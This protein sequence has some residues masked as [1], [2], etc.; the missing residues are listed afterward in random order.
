MAAAWTP[1]GGTSLNSARQWL[2]RLVPGSAAYGSA[3][4]DSV[5][6]WAITS[7]NRAVIPN[8]LPPREAGQSS[9]HPAGR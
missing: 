7:L 3:A 6:H 2:Y 8:T 9:T 5:P 1:C 4:A